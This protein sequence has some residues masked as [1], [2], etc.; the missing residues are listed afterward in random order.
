MQPGEI[1]PSHQNPF[2]VV[3]IGLSGKAT[4]TSEKKNMTIE[5]FETVF[6]TSDEQ[7]QMENLTWEVVRI[8]VVK[9]L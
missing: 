2:D 8:M 9:L 5:P 6:V 3:F 1:I 7:R 4:L